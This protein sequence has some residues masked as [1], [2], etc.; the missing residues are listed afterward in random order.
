MK[1]ALLPA[2]SETLQT[3]FAPAPFSTSIRKLVTGF[4]KVMVI[5]FTRPGSD[6]VVPYTEV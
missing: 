4:W 3:I 2:L 5:G 6:D 1:V